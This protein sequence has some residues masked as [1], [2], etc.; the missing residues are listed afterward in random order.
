MQALLDTNAFLWW[1]TNDSKLSTAARLVI[2]NPNNEIFFSV[3][4]AWEIAI[5]SQI[6][7][8][9][10]PESPK[11]YVPNRVRYYN[12]TVI[13]IKMNDVLQILQ[14]TD[15]HNDPFDRLLIAQSQTRDLPIITVDS[16][17]AHYE[18]DIIW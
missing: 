12:F 15:Y 3:V 1:V 2:G 9:P 18:V 10:L 13:E 6:G 11:Q 7:K 17:F 8:L 14:L 5:K 16:K 4:S